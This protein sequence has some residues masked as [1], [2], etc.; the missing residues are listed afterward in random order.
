MN[1]LTTSRRLIFSTFL[2]PQPKPLPGPA[3]AFLSV[4]PGHSHWLWPRRFHLTFKGPSGEDPQLQLPLM[5]FGPKVKALKWS[6]QT[7]RGLVFSW[8]GASVEE[9]PRRHRFLT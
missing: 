4:P 5:G 8:A 6:D 9:A 2:S 3:L 1:P 7:P